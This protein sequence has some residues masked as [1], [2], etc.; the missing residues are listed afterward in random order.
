MQK[1][2]TTWLSDPNDKNSGK[3]AVLP[4]TKAWASPQ[5][6]DHP[7]AFVPIL[8]DL[9][10]PSELSGPSENSSAELSVGASPAM[11]MKWSWSHAMTCAHYMGQS[12]G[13]GCCLARAEQFSQFEINKPSFAEFCPLV[14]RYGELLH[15]LAG[16]ANP[17]RNPH[18]TSR[19]WA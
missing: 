18:W 2:S 13:I 1:N 16:Q 19:R 11:R 6:S 17:Q 15:D 10:S 7:D 8:G 12:C 5:S 4:S 14:Q 9:T 3:Q